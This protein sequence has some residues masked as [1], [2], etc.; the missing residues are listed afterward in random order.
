[1]PLIDDTQDWK[2]ISSN[3]ND[4]HTIFQFSR[5]YLTCDII[6]DL[7]ISSQTLTRVIFAYGTEDPDSVNTVPIHSYK[8]SKNI[9]LLQSDHLEDDDINFY[10][11]TVENVG[12]FHALL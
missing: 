9:L 12:H 5:F 7:E 8:G 11:F 3:E 1:M 6:H 4:T 10:K 2:I